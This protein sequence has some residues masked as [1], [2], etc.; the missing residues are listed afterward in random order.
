LTAGAGASTSI[1]LSN[2]DNR[3]PHNLS[4]KGVATSATCAGP[5]SV[6]L[7]FVAPAPGS[8]GFI[9]TVHPFMTGTLTV[10]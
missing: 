6:T 7:S 3:V 5:C 2:Q 10:R 8:Y 4:V 1:V 9:C